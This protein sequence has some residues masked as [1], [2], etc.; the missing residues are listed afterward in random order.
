MFA[1]L[2]ITLADRSHVRDFRILLSAPLSA[3]RQFS[4]GGGVRR[5][6]EASDAAATTTAAAADG[7]AGAITS[8]PASATAAAAAA[9]GERKVIIGPSSHLLSDAVFIPS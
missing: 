9:A 1:F 2:H 4:Y 6:S 8:F 3:Q 5:L 7:F